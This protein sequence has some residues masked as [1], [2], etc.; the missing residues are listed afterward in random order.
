MEEPEEKPP[1]SFD[2]AVAF[3]NSKEVAAHCF[4]CGTSPGWE[5]IASI[6]GGDGKPTGRY[7]ALATADEM[8]TLYGVADPMVVVTCNNC[9][10]I[11]LHS[12]LKIR[13]LVKKS[14]GA[15]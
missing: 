4:S 10:F 8:G 5:L 14:T 9:G 3:L 2:D 12:L 1:F 11:K 13:E 15:N 7:R 6:E